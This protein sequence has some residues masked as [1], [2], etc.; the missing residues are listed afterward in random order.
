M[1]TLCF[2]SLLL[3]LLSYGQG[4]IEK[5]F[6]K[7]KYTDCED[8]KN[9]NKKKQIRCLLIDVVSD[10]L[11]YSPSQNKISE[12]P[13]NSALEA[14]TFIQ[15]EY[16]IPIAEFRCW[17]KYQDYYVFALMCGV[18]KKTCFFYCIYYIKKGSSE[19]RMFVPRT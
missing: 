16:D 5:S 3:V 9:G 6:A 18:K 13:I 10:S 2:C 1:K 17:T 11:D 4:N 14:F 12:K 7:L 19:C 8:F 15:K